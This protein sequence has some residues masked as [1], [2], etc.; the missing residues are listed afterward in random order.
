MAVNVV[1]TEHALAA[2]RAAGVRRFVHVGTEAVLADG[3]PIIRA[4]ESRPQPGKPAGPYPFTKGLAETAVVE[5]SGEGLETVVVRPRCSG[6][7]SALATS[8]TGRGAKK[9]VLLSIVAV[10]PPVGGRLAQA[11]VPPQ[12]SASAISTPPCATLFRLA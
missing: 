2:A 8:P 3:K 1:G 12:L 11:A 7:V 5:A 4:D 10:E 6:V 9:F